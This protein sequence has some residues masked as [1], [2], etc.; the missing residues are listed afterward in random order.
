MKSRKIVFA[1]PNQ[2]ELQDEMYDETA[3]ACGE[4]AVKTLHTLI[5]PG[6][7]MACLAGIESWFPLP[8]TPGY[9]AV[10]EVIATGSGVSRVQPGDKVYFFGNN[11]AYQTVAAGDLLAKVPAGVDLSLVPFTR[12][13]TIAIT[14]LRVVPV[15][16]GDTVLITGLGLVG[17]M[18]AQ[19]AK[20]AG[21]TVIAADLSPSRRAL[22][23]RCGADFVLDPN[24]DDVA[25]C[26]SQ[27]TGGAGVDALIEASGMSKVLAD[28]L[29]LIRTYGDAVLLGSPRAPYLTDITPLY[30]Q[31]HDGKCITIKGASE[32]RVP[33]LHTP[34]LKHSIERNTGVVLALLAQ[35]KLNIEPLRTHRFTPEQAPQ[36]YEGVRQD[37]DRYL[38]VVFDW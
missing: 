31:S 8:N 32:W 3:L 26:V 27:Q 35:K 29:P 24:K 36:A 5:S 20:L 12:M 13:A 16:L 17:N 28:H 18:A 11:R 33:M 38:G 19:L 4:V 2:V 14:A 21:A 7:D 9:T 23:L 15:E 30:R 10:G 37:K 34:H 1:A 25:R 22:A 6:T